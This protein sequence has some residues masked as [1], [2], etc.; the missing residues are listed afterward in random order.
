[1]GE[2]EWDAYRQYHD[3]Q[4]DYKGAPRQAVHNPPPLDFAAS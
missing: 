1:M 3:R 2:K 4:P